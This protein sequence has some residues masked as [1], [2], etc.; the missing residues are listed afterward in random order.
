MYVHLL[1]SGLCKNLHVCACTGL[2]TGPDIL[3]AKF[4][5]LRVAFIVDE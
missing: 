3:M 5:L 2:L 4:T 1:V